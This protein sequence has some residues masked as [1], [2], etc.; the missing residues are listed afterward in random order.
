MELE[1]QLKKCNSTNPVTILQINSHNSVASQVVSVISGYG[2]Y[3]Y[4]LDMHIFVSSDTEASLVPP[5]QMMTQ[6]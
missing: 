5:R 2:L 1:M 6:V 3:L 4:F